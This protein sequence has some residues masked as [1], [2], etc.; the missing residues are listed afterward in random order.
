M[1]QGLQLRKLL[2][3][4]LDCNRKDGKVTRRKS[5]FFCGNKS[6][7]VPA[8]TEIIEGASQ[9]LQ[10]LINLSPKDQERSENIQKRLLVSAR[11]EDAVSGARKTHTSDEEIQDAIIEGASRANSR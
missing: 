4:L 8:M 2:I 1:Q 11:F 10:E 7:I 6:G 3:D 5:G 9:E